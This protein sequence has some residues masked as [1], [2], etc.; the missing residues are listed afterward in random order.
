MYPPYILAIIGVYSLC[1]SLLA[2]G[3]Y[4]SFAIDL[5]ELSNY[6]PSKNVLLT[7]ANS[8]SLRRRC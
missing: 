3:G 4:M 2:R 7:A 8:K 6:E 5:Y 1:P